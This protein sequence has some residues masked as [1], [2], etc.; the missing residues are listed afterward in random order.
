MRLL[1][2]TITP[3]IE[4]SRPPQLVLYVLDPEP[5]LFVTAVAALHGCAL[6]FVRVLLVCLL[7]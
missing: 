5:E 2:F 4:R 3:A 6:E 7:F 1:S